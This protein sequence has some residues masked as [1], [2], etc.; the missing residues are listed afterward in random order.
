MS[1]SSGSIKSTEEPLFTSEFLFM[2]IKKRGALSEG[3][4]VAV[5]EIMKNQGSIHR[6]IK[7]GNILITGKE[8]G[9][10]SIIMDF[11]LATKNTDEAY[12]EHLIWSMVRPDLN[13][14]I[15]P[16]DAL[17]HPAITGTV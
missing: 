2:G 13:R 5:Q 7:L 1:S 17:K 12:M 15:S 6:D 8:E 16:E 14:M 10:R 11:G 9:V 3:Q 4:Q